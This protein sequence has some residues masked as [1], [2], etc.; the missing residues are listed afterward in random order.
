MCTNTDG[1]SIV[2]S[3][4]SRSFLNEAA[5]VLAMGFSNKKTNNFVYK[6]GDI[7]VKY[8]EDTSLHLVPGFAGCT[9]GET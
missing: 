8:Y 2:L 6:N 7:V 1:R 9:A 5:T 3:L 4:V